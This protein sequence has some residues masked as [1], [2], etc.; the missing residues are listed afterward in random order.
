MDVVFGSKHRHTAAAVSG[1][2]FT[3]R[4]CF[5]QML[6]RMKTVKASSHMQAAHTQHMT[7]LRK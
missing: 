4:E 6:E 7:E 5:L 2:I 1:D 3:V